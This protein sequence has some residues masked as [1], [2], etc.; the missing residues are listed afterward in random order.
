MNCTHLACLE[1]SLYG[2]AWNLDDRETIHSLCYELDNND[3]KI[4]KLES[5]LSAVQ[6]RK[7]SNSDY[8]IAHGLPDDDCYD[9]EKNI[10]RITNEIEKRKQQLRENP[11]RI[12][13]LIAAIKTECQ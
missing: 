13:Q 9:L 5:E 8:S 11:H 6:E 1:A 12:K 3:K 10:R 2:Y 4:K 7:K